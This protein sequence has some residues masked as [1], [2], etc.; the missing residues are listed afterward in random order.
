MLIL[1]PREPRK[2]YRVNYTAVSDNP[3]ISVD[4]AEQFA[5]KVGY[6]VGVYPFTI[7][8]DEQGRITVYLN[9]R[10]IVPDG[11]SDSPKCQP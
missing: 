7:D 6:S 3:A 4:D 1:S 8:I 2:L 5:Q 10:E 11:W 9:G